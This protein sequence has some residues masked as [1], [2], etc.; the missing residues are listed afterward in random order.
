MFVFLLFC[1]SGFNKLFP[2]Y[3][4]SNIRNKDNSGYNVK[5]NPK[6]THYAPSFPKLIPIAAE[7]KLPAAI[8]NLNCNILMNRLGLKRRSGIPSVG[9]SDDLLKG[10]V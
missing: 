5:N 10:I 8:G 4:V 1:F 2:A 9:L 3:S 6:Q 7:L